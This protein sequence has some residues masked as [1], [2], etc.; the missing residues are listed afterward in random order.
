MNDRTKIGYLGVGRYL[1]PT[2][3]TNRDFEKMVD[4]S[5]EWIQ[6]RTGIKQRHI[7]SSD[8]DLVSMATKAAR[9][10]LE[11]A[12]IQAEQISS[13]YVGSNT[14]LRFPSLASMV[15]N[16]LGIP[17]ASAADIQAGCSGYIFAVETIYNRMMVDY[18]LTGKTSYALAIGADSMSPVVNWNDRT[19]CVLF[20]DGAGAAVIGPV[21]TGGILATV[22]RT[23]GKYHDLLAMDQFLHVPTHG[24]DD[25]IM[26]QLETIP[27]PTLRMEGTKVFPVAVRSMMG[28]IKAVIEKYNL[29]N[30]ASMSVDDIEFVIPHQANLRIVSAVQEGL[31]L[32]PDQVHSAG[33]INFG[34]T[35]A[36]TIPIA[37]V[38]EWGKRPG[39]LQID[40][41]F[42]A[43]FASGAILWRTPEN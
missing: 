2:V 42:G 17:N 18:L 29:I 25:L 43:G 31:H 8:E 21:K 27:Y 20:G 6:Q 23:Q 32:R 15:Q 37:Y 38:D 14:H 35:S 41:S 26:R 16:E 11:N 4:T 22:T 40:V 33:V 5:D 7:L 28:D 30:N 10:A 19:T 1:P 24:A 34:N 3:L 13:I 36:A 12:G 9:A 39:S